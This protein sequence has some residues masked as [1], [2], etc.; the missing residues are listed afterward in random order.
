MTLQSLCERRERLRL[1]LEAICLAYHEL[2][3][4]ATEFYD[5]HLGRLEE[6]ASHYFRAV[7]QRRGRRVSLDGHRGVQETWGRGDCILD[8]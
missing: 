3:Q 5:S 1:E 6:R 4:A 7:S 8:A 2:A